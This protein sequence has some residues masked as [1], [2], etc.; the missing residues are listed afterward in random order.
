[1]VC[2]FLPGAGLPGVGLPGVE[3]LYDF[4]L[5]YFNMKRIVCKGMLEPILKTLIND[6]IRRSG[7]RGRDRHGLW[8]RARTTR[9]VIAWVLWEIHQAMAVN[10]ATFWKD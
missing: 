9:N 4:N 10:N 1:M 7:R 3:R 2:S 5:L 8:H 6:V